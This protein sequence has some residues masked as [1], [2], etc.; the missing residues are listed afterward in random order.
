MNARSAA[1]GCMGGLCLLLPALGQ[2]QPSFAKTLQFWN[3]KGFIDRFMATY[4]VKSEVEPKISADENDLFKELIP[5]IQSSPNQA[6]VKL[7]EAITPE[8][9]AAL[10]FTLGNLYVQSNNYP[11][12]VVQYLS[13][14]HI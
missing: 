10:E 12:A 5:L 13:L 8:S 7:T 6:I 2:A 14:I 9:S 4:G 1:L 3:N 11:Q